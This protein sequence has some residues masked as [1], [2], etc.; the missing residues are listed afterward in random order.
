M[1]WFVSAMACLAI[2]LVMVFLWPHGKER[3]PCR[4][5]CRFAYWHCPVQT[6]SIG[7]VCQI[8]YA[9]PSAESLI[10]PL[11]N[12]IDGQFAEEV[13]GTFLESHPNTEEDIGALSKLV[14]AVKM[15]VIGRPIPVVQISLTAS[16]ST[17]A[18]GLVDAYVETLRK[19]NDE[20]QKK[21]FSSA[22]NQISAN[23]AKLKNQLDGMANKKASTSMTDGV[24]I[25]KL[26]LLKKIADLESDLHQMRSS[27]DINKLSIQILTKTS[28]VP[29][30]T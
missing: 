29:C 25:S 3:R 19:Q 22:E 12:L 11:M 4:A 1:K 15:E 27:N 14:A 6:N 8:D 30:S 17:V 5:E 28:V 21:L 24:E 7:E 9:G 20:R 13:V 16:S 23:I 26:R 18:S 2:V 10:K